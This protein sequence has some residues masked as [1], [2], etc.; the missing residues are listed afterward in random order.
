MPKRQCE[1]EKS[2]L[3]EICFL[4]RTNKILYP[5][6]HLGFTE[7]NPCA[8][9]DTDISPATDACR[10]LQNTLRKNAF[11]CTLNGPFDNLFLTRLSASRAL[12][13]GIIAV[14]SVSTVYDLIF[15]IIAP[16]FSSVNRFFEKKHKKMCKFA[17]EKIEEFWKETCEKYVFHPRRSVFRYFFCPASMRSLSQ[18][19]C[20]ALLCT[21]TDSAPCSIKGR[22]A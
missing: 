14:I 5:R 4:S 18:A 20:S 11:H 6:C 10:T 22:T 7:K 9:Q 1:K 15:F 19:F 8:L 3:T 17:V 13:K 21:G 2:P 16:C 12:W